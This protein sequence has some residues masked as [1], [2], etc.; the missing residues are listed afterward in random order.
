MQNIKAHSIS[1]SI[2]NYSNRVKKY[3]GP[4]SKM[5]QLLIEARKEQ[6]TLKLKYSRIFDKKKYQSVEKDQNSL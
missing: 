6:D 2:L 5:S 1:N 4:E 3:V